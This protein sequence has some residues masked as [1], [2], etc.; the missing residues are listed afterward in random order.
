MFS[1]FALNWTSQSYATRIASSVA[2]AL[3]VGLAVGGVLQAVFSSLEFWPTQN[4]AAARYAALSLGLMALLQ[5]VSAMLIAVIRTKPHDSLTRAL[6]RLTHVLGA[7]AIW[8]VL[9]WAISTMFLKDSRF[10]FLHFDDRGCAIGMSVLAMVALGSF[11]IK[12]LVKGKFEDA[13]NPIYKFAAL[14]LPMAVVIVLL[15]L[16]PETIALFVTMTTLDV[17]LYPIGLGY[18]T[19]QD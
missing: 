7:D 18:F 1:N 5:C 13:P 16:S 8:L 4:L 12:F 10:S 17:L 19:R 11:A 2:F 3:A 9:A 15:S 6:S 14:K